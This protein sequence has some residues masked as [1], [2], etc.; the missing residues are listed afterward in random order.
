MRRIALLAS[1]LMLTGCT[2]YGAF[3]DHVIA[4]P[5]GNPNMPVAD[6]Q[7]LRRVLGEDASASPLLPET[8]NVWP[9]P[10]G[11]D[12]TLA[13]LQ[14][15][16]STGPARGFVPTTVPGAARG[17]PDHRQPRPLGSS[18]PPSLET[19]DP[20]SRPPPGIGP[21]PPPPRSSVPGPGPLGSVVQTPRGPAV[22]AGGTGSYRQLLTP[23]GPGAIMVPNGNGTSTILSPGGGIQTIPTPR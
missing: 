2:G 22:D 18:T 10:Q 11:P 14:S 5:G 20:V 16:D 12:P 21:I 4:V 15:R 1:A 3:L 23:Q 8:G 13:D 6:S 17:L 9:G 7:N 19:L